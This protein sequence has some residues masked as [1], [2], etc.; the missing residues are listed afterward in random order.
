MT[1]FGEKST[2]N[3]QTAVLP[4]QNMST[5]T[6]SPTFE[7]EQSFLLVRPLFFST[8]DPDQSPELSIVLD[9]LEHK[10][11]SFAGDTHSQGKWGSF[12]KPHHS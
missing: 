11:E 8:L 4:E 3:N 5:V 2:I 7:V 1:L 10:Q 12:Q 6:A 9:G